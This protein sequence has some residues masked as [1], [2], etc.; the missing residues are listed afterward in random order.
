LERVDQLQNTLLYLRT[1]VR[2]GDVEVSKRLGEEVFDMCVACHSEVKV[3]YLFRFPQRTTIFGEYMHKISDHADLARIYME[4]SVPGETELQ[5]K[6]IGYY[7]GLLQDVF[8]EQGPSGV[9]MD[10]EGFNNR[11]KETQAITKDLQKALRE[12][13][14]VDIEDYKKK[15]NGLCVACHEPERLK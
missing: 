10:R 5:F 13:G 4:E 3:P 11:L 2:G 7:L 8:P 14:A 6:L 15:L 9:I 1:A 12:K